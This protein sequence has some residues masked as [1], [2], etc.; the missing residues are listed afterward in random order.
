MKN[1]KIT[2]AKP[3]YF[4]TIGELEEANGVENRWAVTALELWSL[5]HMLKPMEDRL[6]KEIEALNLK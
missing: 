5:L 4:L 6:V 1:V 2:E 3:G